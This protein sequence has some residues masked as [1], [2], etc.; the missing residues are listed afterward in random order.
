LLNQVIHF[1]A[2]SVSASTQHL[3]R[4]QQYNLVG[5]HCKG[6]VQLVPISVHHVP[7]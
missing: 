4:R 3:R 5:A 7:D 2:R 6:V 1:S